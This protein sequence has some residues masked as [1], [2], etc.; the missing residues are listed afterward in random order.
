MELR[1]GHFKDRLEIEAVLVDYCISCGFRFREGADYE[2]Q[3]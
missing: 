1:C 3:D 2:L